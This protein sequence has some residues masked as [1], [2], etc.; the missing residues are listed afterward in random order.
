MQNQNAKAAEPGGSPSRT[1]TRTGRRTLAL[2]VL[3]FLAPVVLATSL[4][5]GGWRPDGKGLQ[6]GELLQPA[7][8]LTNASLRKTDSTEYRLHAVRGSWTFIT[9]SRLPC[10]DLCQKNLYK[11]QQVCLAQGKDAGRV[12]RAFITLGGTDDLHALEAKYPGLAA[13]TGTP[14]A[15]QTLAREFTSSHGT[16]LDGLERVYLV[17]PNGNLVLS[18]AADADASGMRKDLARLL[19][20]SQIG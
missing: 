6:Q 9:F 3:L 12:Q 14:A 20:L 7:R 11:M 4:Y 19:R 18:Y 16:P 2:I 5:F 17:D 1:A 10:N 15:V 8:P 13:F